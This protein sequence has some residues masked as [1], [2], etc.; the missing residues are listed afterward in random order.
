MHMDCSKLMTLFLQ[1]CKIATFYQF[2][3]FASLHCTLAFQK[4]YLINNPTM[5]NLG[6]DLAEKPSFHKK[7]YFYEFVAN[8]LRDDIDILIFDLH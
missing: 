1:R 4:P 7:N 3:I 8:V 6:I 5:F 2:Y